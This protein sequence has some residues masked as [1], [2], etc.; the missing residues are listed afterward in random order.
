MN[1]G[2]VHSFHTAAAADG[3]GVRFAIFLSGCP[4]R[5]KY[6]HNPDTW[7]MKRGTLR[8]VDSLLDEIKKYA[9]FL[10]MAG[11][12][13]ITGGEPLAQSEF[14][15]EIFSRVKQ[16]FSLH[17]ALD[18][19]GFLAG[20]LPDAYFEPI[21]L[22]LLDIKEMNPER[23]RALTGKELRPTLDFAL[24]LKRLNK[25]VWLRYVLVPGLTDFAE[26]IEALAEFIRPL[27]NI[28][29][30]DVLPFHN[31]ALHKWEELQFPYELKNQRSPTQEEV[32]KVQEFLNSAI[33]SH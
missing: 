4:F 7:E 26:D 33:S 16:E 30:V 24:R 2:Y 1:Q 19:Q 3:P 14:T 5:C 8:T 11:G 17:T 22:I 13:T 12:L 21:D 18:T 31:M 9:S 15:Y 23:H 29:R 6:C 32:K 27:S 28:E 20:T 25:K 10:R